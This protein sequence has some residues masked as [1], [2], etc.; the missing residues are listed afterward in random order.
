MV[1]E[2]QALTRAAATV[3]MIS[4]FFAR[5]GAF[6]VVWRLFTLAVVS[7]GAVLVVF[8][9]VV[10]LGFFFSCF[11]EGFRVYGLLIRVSTWSSDCLCRCRQHR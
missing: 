10:S 11:A 5:C 1:S 3:R 4:V 7:V 8:I 9:V 6:V 2:S